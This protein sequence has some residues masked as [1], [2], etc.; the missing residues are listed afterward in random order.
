MKFARKAGVPVNIIKNYITLGD[1]ATKRNNFT[2]ALL[3]SDTLL[4]YITPKTNA[5]VRSAFRST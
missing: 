4:T 5:N 1:V 3:Y 2:E